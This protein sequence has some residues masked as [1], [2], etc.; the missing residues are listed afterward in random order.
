VEVEFSEL[1]VEGAKMFRS[2]RTPVFDTRIRLQKIAAKKP[3][4]YLGASG[5][6]SQWRNRLLR[7]VV[8][9]FV[10]GKG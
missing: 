10:L 9:G 4:P 1:R 5:G 2:Y 8:A 6:R 7:E 3:A